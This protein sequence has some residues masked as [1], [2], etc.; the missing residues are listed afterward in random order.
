MLAFRRGGLQEIVRDAGGECIDPQSPVDDA[1]A[2]LER[3]MRL[4]RA[5]VCRHAESVCD[6]DTMIDRYVA[7]YEELA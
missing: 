7:L 2:A 4:D 3:V 6:I 5:G 1:V